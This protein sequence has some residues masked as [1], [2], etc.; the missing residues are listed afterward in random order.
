MVDGERCC[1]FFFFSFTLTGSEGESPADNAEAVCSRGQTEARPRLPERRAP[2]RRHQRQRSLLRKTAA[3]RRKWRQPIPRRSELRTGELQERLLQQP[4]QQ[5]EGRGRWRHVQCDWQGEGQGGG[6]DR[7]EAGPWRWNDHPTVVKDGRAF[8]WAQPC[9]WPPWFW[10]GRGIDDNNNNN[11]NNNS[12][13]L[14]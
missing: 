7:S 6:A 10:K 1:T 12:G 5:R 8:H 3:R 9:S 2:L 14:R 4:C 13:C 11:N